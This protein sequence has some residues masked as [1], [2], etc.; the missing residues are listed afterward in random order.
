MTKNE[1]GLTDPLSG[2]SLNTVATLKQQANQKSLP[3]SR[4]IKMRSLWMQLQP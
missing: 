4:I 1:Q 2:E 3:I